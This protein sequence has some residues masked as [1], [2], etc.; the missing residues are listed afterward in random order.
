MRHYIGLFEMGRTNQT[1][2]CMGADVHLMRTNR[3]ILASV[4]YFLVM[5]EG[6]PW[7]KRKEKHPQH[8]CSEH[9]FHMSAFVV[10]LQQNYINRLSQN[11]FIVTITLTS[12]YVH[13]YSAQLR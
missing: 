8:C 10:H 11:D 13:A 9:L 4:A 1:L 5:V 6:R 3:F 2:I 12:G 7:R